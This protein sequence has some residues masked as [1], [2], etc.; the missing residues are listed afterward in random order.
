[1]AKKINLKIS[2]MHCASC[3]ALV[4][5][6][7]QKTDGV[8]SANVN[9]STEK[10]H[11]EYDESKL[12]VP[13]L[14]EAVKKKGYGATVST[15]ADKG[16]EEL[17]KKREIVE[18]RRLLIGSVA[19][20]LPAFLIGM[21][22]MDFPYRIFVLF[23][24]CTPIQF[25]AGSR[26][27]RGA[28]A[29]AQNRTSNMDTLVAVGTSAA[30]IY[31]VAIMLTKP[32]ADQYFETSAVLITFVLAGKY[33]EM[34]AKGRTGE[35]IRKLMDLRPK[36]AT[37]VR[38]GVEA[39][40]PV[41]S[42]RA[43]DIVVVKPG[44]K[45]PV[46][47][48]IVSGSSSI[49]E[50]MITGESI[51]VEKTAGSTVIGSTINKHGSFRFKATKVGSETTLAQIIRLVEDAQGSRAP[52]QRFADVVSSYF[53][54]VVI[55]I[56]LLSFLAWY[57]IMGKSFA[58]ALTIAVSVLVIS[59]PCALGLATPTAIM[60]GV[61]RGAGEG[62]LIKS[63]D[64]LETAHR[65]N[66]VVLDKTG[67]LTKGKPSVTDF[68]VL[69]GFSEETVLQYVGA[70]E[71]NSEHPLAEAVL[72]YVKAKGVAPGEPLDFKAVPGQGVEAIVDFKRVVLGNRAL[73][74]NEKVDCSVLEPRLCRLEDEG[75]T[76][77]TLSVDGKLAAIVAIADTIKESSKEAVER[78]KKMRIKVYMI[79]GDNRRTAEAVGRQLGVD[80]VFAEVLPQD[81]AGHVKKLQSEGMKVAM[82]GD[83]INDAPALAQAD[84]GVAMASGTDVAMESGGIVLMR[85]D[86]LDIVKAIRLSKATMGKI[87]QNMF[88][89]LFYNTLGIPV[90]AGLL[91]PFT[92]WLLSPIIAGGAMALSSV[93]VVTNSLLLKYGRLD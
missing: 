9:L 31:S 51:P 8:V 93:S 35:A 41:D 90:A 75:K 91:Y 27:Y 18:L 33:L 24:L 86:P 25:I 50:S 15:E 56:A 38:D 16:L 85:N 37:V 36:T 26:F 12:D 88:W 73:L 1:M 54:P 74:S 23:L 2:G 11:V 82:V 52:I 48:I 67:T 43:G 55:I 14:I 79:T 57:F 29:A 61:G 68:I 72:E 22:I 66:A 45:V 44:E 81:K 10:A 59:C 13:K 62:V 70:V 60:V 28:W 19:I 6:G 49:D 32:M 42:V 20:A 17:E 71:K 46:D 21:F 5:R 3:S 87:R 84:V 63:G 58:F 92:G 40:V 80:S 30:Y 89:A 39:V 69:E 4:T 47:G 83:G 64:A 7:L 34:S 77:V 53:V 65:I 78:L 76:A